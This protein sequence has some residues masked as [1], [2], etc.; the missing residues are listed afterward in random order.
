MSKHH[1]SWVRKLQSGQAWPEKAINPGSR[2]P[3]TEEKPV[4]TPNVK[5]EDDSNGWSFGGVVSSGSVIWY[6][7]TE[8]KR[9]PSLNLPLIEKLRAASPRIVSRP[10]MPDY[11]QVITGWRAWNVVPKDGEWRLAALG[12]GDIWEPKKAMTANCRRVSIW[13]THIEKTH[14]S[15]EKNCACGIWSFRSDEELM[16][17]SNE[18]TFKVFGQV[19]I[20]GRVIECENGWRSQFAYP[21]ELWLIDN[22][23]EQ[24]GYIYGV[25]VRTI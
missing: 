25:P 21:K 20:W 16:K 5:K 15:P 24:L 19:S 10:E 23:L 9:E 14:I 11:T 1:K 6:G 13:D 22:S 8:V 2:A 3:I 7:A 12:V 18:Y 17:H 4:D